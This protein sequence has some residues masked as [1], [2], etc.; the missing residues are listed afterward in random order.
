MYHRGEKHKEGKPEHGEIK[1]GEDVTIGREWT[2]SP[3][4]ETL[5]VAADARRAYEAAGSGFSGAAKGVGAAAAV[6]VRDVLNDLPFMQGPRNLLESVQ[7]EQ[8]MEAFAGNALGSLV[9][10]DVRKYAQAQDVETLPSG[11]TV[12]VE[13]KAPGAL[14][15][16]MKNIPGQR[17]KL[18]KSGYRE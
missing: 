14:D 5:M 11:K 7:S 15:K 16:L 17:Q 18:Q 12:H 6:T 3:L 9:P 13:R 1:F 4:M 10:P 2:H 8:K